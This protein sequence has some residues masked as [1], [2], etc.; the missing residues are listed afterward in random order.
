MEANLKIDELW[1]G[2]KESEKSPTDIGTIEMIVR[3]PQVDEREEVAESITR[4]LSAARRLR[5]HDVDAD[6][7]PALVF[8]PDF[9]M[10]QSNATLKKLGSQEISL[11]CKWQIGSKETCRR[12]LAMT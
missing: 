7:V 6:Q 3:R 11:H 4:N 12:T 1:G 9:F 2:W 8:R 10:A 5:E